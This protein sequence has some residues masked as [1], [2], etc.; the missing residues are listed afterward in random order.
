MTTAV[1]ASA[2]MVVP[3]GTMMIVKKTVTMSP[4][5]PHAAAFSGRVS[6]LAGTRG[7]GGV[8]GG[9]AWRPTVAAAKSA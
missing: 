9:W 3:L 8:P 7:G 2:R 6:G 4:H 1:T 5:T